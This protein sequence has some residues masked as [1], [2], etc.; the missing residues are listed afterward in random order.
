MP[1]LLTLNRTLA[2]T[3]GSRGRIKTIVLM[4][5]YLGKEKKCK[6]LT[7]NLPVAQ[8]HLIGLDVEKLWQLAIQA[9]TL[10]NPGH[11]EVEKDYSSNKTTQLA[12][13]SDRQ[14]LVADTKSIQSSKF[15]EQCDFTPPKFCSG[16]QN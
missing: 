10:R 12:A 1:L 9:T 11:L 15:N 14:S 16:S 8:Q 6:S 2:S 4:N 3:L 13:S 7:H 5:S